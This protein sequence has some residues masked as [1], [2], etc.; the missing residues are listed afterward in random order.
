[1][2]V[3][4]RVSRSCTTSA[5]GMYCTAGKVASRNSSAAVVSATSSPLTRTCTRPLVGSMLIGCPALGSLISGWAMVVP[6]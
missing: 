1:M 4:V 5:I 3:S 2:L 6:P